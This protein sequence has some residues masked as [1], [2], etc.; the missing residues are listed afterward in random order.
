V[1][2]RIENSQLR[3]RARKLWERAEAERATDRDLEECIARFR[4]APTLP[5]SGGGAPHVYLF[6]IISWTHLTQ[7]P[8]HFAR[9]LASTGY[10]V[11][12][13]DVQL[14]S[15][16]L[17][18]NALFREMEPNLYYVE[19]PGPAADLYSLRWTSRTLT[20]M[21][22]AILYLSKAFEATSS[23]QLVNYPKWTP[24]VQRLRSQLSWPV[25]YD[26]LDDQK[27]FASLYPNPDSDFEQELIRDSSLVI[28]S[29][30]SLFE[31]HAGGNPNTVLI[32][33]AADFDLFSRAKPSGVLDAMRRPIIG[34]FGAFAEWLDLDWI[35]EAARRFP[36]WT[37]LYIGREVFSSASAQD[38]WRKTVAVNNVTV[39]PQMDLGKLAQYLAGFDVCIMPFLDL[40]ITRS[41]NPVK[42][43]E[44]LA[45]GKPVVAPDLPEIRPFA[46]RELVATYRDRDQ[47]FELL[48]RAVK[49]GHGEELME[50]RKRFASRN[51]WALRTV[52]LSAALKSVCSKS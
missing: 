35:S 47:S 5:H 24:L 49:F 27:A 29:G 17:T 44:Y 50:A 51:T 22:E 4:N 52:E 15:P 33:N 32:P 45:A 39:M 16:A 28:T 9:G 30:K 37:F 13:I 20:A 36:D 21:E 23:V 1:P 48:E 10:R 3:E 19:L 18:P 8:H 11:F 26:C 40:P 41:M 25:V 42:I 46:E 34:F 6:N 38:T 43:F 7:R 2:E 31:A 14:Q 12:W